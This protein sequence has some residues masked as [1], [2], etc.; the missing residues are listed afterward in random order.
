MQARGFTIDYLA[1]VPE[2]KDTVEKRS[3]LHHLVTMVLDQF[4]DSTDLFSELG[5][6]NRCAKVQSCRELYGLVS[7]GTECKMVAVCL[8]Y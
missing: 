1:H 6:V 5:A 4:P 8:P 7:R 2:V 3:L